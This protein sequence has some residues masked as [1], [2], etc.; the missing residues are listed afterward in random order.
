MKI[1]KTI[2]KQVGFL[3]LLILMIACVKDQDYS[4]PIVDCTEPTITITNTI[5]QVKE[6]YTFGGATI[7]ERDVIIEGY[8]V[9]NDESGNIYKAISIQD[10]PVNPTAAIK[11]SIDQTDLYTKYN[12]GRKIYVKL[13]GLAI[14]Y[15]FGSLQIGTGDGNELGRIPSTEINDYII[16]SCEVVEIIPKVMDISNLNKTHLEMLIEIENVQFK[17]S[18]LGK[19]YGNLNNSATVNRVLES[20]NQNCNYKDN[21]IL[22]NSGYS[23]FKNELLPEEKGSVVAIFSNYYED[24]QLYI[25]DTNDVNLEEQRCDYSETLT[26]TISLVEVKEMYEGTMVEFG[27][28]NEYIVEGYVVSSD[29]AGISKI[30]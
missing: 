12:V 5:Q 3:V 2:Q 7:I 23:N 8:V 13:K 15:S 18:E 4:T 24:F 30:S 19:S 26:P 22:R 27:V 21:I 29:L 16:R 1:Y 6:M 25:R 17:N 20:F 9:S 14:G 10:K 28:T 11:I